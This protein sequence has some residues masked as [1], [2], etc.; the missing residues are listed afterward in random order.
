MN[1]AGQVGGFLSP[2]LLA[3]I[4]RIT[5]SWSQPLYL[6][7]VLFSLGAVCWCFIDA[8]R[9]IRLSEKQVASVTGAS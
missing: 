6:T 2:I 9:P 3:Y 1:T 8:T 5:G 7:G 4:I